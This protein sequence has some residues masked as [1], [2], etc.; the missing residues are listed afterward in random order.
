[1]FPLK[2]SS[3]KITNIVYLNDMMGKVNGPD[4]AIDDEKGKKEKIDYF[5]KIK[6]SQISSSMRYF[7][8]HKVS[9]STGK[10]DFS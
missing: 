5:P 7:E 3:S 9:S 6:K 1:M 2:I 4:E 8:Q 10:A